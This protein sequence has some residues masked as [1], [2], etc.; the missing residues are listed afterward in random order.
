MF[1]D[2]NYNED[3][4]LV[5]RANTN[6][7]II[8]KDDAFRHML[9]MFNSEEVITITNEI[10]PIKADTYCI[11]GDTSHAE[12]ILKHIAQKLKNENIVIEKS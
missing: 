8:N 9:R 2:R 10:K 7:L 6:A 4:T 11:H 12:D 3:L 1:I 5:S